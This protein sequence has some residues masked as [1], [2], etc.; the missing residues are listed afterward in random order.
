MTTR[1]EAALLLRSS[2]PRLRGATARLRM[3][4][5]KGA[6][7]PQTGDGAPGRRTSRWK[8][9]EDAWLWGGG[10]GVDPETWPLQ[11]VQTWQRGKG[12]WILL[13]ALENH[14]MVLS[15]EGKQSDSCF[16]DPVFRVNSPQRE[17]MEGG[18]M[19]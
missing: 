7:H 8:A 6:R 4:G 2:G 9:R 17:Q 3:R 16:K 13:C 5:R 1:N 14:Q 12:L 10:C 18:V 15:K 19:G 11:G